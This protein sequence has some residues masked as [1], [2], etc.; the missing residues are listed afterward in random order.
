[1]AHQVYSGYG[2][3][4]KLSEILQENRPSGIFLVTGKASYSSSGAETNIAPIISDYHYERFFDFENNVKVEDLKRGIREF[5]EAKCDFVIGIGGGSVI[6]MAKAISLLASQDSAPEEYILG[7]ASAAPRRVPSV[8]IPTT[9]GTGSESTRFSVVYIDKTKY[10]LS[11]PSLLPDYAILD[12][13][14]TLNAS[15]YLTACTGMD[16]LSQGI[17]SYWSVQSTDES[18]LFSREAI[19]LALANIVKAVNSPDRKTRENMLTASN[20][21]GRAINIAYTTAAHAVSYPLTSFFD[22]P[23]GHAVAL[24]L[25]CFM[26]HNSIMT[27]NNLQDSRGIDFAKNI[28]TDLIKFLGANSIEEAVNNLKDIIKAIHLENRLSRLGITDTDFDTIARFGFNPERMKNN[29][30]SV[31]EA[32]LRDILNKIK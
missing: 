19:S 1:M 24:T 5:K 16:V 10:S 30:V 6:D 23:H 3:F 11:H 14:F 12:P 4:N 15:Q 22:I 28:I 7:K 25:P 32:E 9:A 2:S 13:S 29:P 8:M 18:R 17:E 26:E 31:S 21:A 27:E 20:L